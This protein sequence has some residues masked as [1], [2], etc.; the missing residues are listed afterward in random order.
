MA[1]ALRR[2]EDAMNRNWRIAFWAV[3]LCVVWALAGSAQAVPSFPKRGDRITVAGEL[4]YIQDKGPA[5]WGLKTAEGNE[6]R[7][8]VPLGMF[9]ELQ[10]AGFDAKVGEKISVEGEVV[11]V[12]AET[13]VIASSEITFHGITY[14]MPRRPS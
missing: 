13:P 2:R 3:I 6:Y 7:I 14:R 5:I 8:Q 1:E 4:T 10:R 9:A 12:M 11:C